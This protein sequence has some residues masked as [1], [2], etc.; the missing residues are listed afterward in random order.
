MHVEI[1]DLLI[2]AFLPFEVAGLT[3]RGQMNILNA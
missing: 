2:C 3:K 1:F